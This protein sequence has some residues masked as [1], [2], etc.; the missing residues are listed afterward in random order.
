MAAALVNVRLFRHRA[1]TTSAV[2]TFLAGVTLYGAMLL[3]LLYWQRVRGE[4]ALGAGLL[5]IPQGIGALLART[6]VGDYTDR[7]GPRRVALLGFALAAAAT[8]PFALA[9]PGTSKV[10]LMA[11]LLV[12][13]VGM[14][15][16]IIPLTSA[17]YFGLAHRE[18]PDASIITRVAQQV[19]G[20]VGTAV[21]AV[22]LQRTTA[23]A[24]DVGAVAHGFGDAFW[25]S[26]GF[27]VAAVPLCLLLPGRPERTV[28]AAAEART[29]A[30]APTPAEA[31]AAVQTRTPVP[32]PEP[33]SSEP[34]T[35]RA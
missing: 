23:G 4:D 33:T 27:T 16:A 6:R 34:L 30:E 35:P 15:A 18:I 11:A 25:W 7:I 12:R 3:L 20:S 21:L 32:V 26:I 1:L 2:L 24:H 17:A 22:V 9:D 10:L 13:G 8:V 19:G 14:G 29:P 5:L 28:Q 31:S